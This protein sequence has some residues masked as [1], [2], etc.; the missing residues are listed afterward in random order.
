MSEAKKSFILAIADAQELLDCYDQL[1]KSKEKNKDNPM[2]PEALKRASLILVLTAWETYVEDVAT[3]LFEQKFGA[4]KGC[5]IGDFMWKQFLTK[6]KT[7]NN[8]DSLKTKQIFEEFF[9]VDITLEW[10]WNNY[11]TPKDVKT[12]LNK[13]ISKRGEA[14]H[15]AQ[16]D[17]QSNHVVK[18]S[19]LDKCIIFFKD[20]V[21]V[22]DNTLLAV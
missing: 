9:G 3:E 10:K 4:L 13:W 17:K 5:L 12:A 11:N 18:R 14:V 19:E 16:P 2:P 15:R 6:L 8:P 7:F 1:N 22:T 21:T 20:L